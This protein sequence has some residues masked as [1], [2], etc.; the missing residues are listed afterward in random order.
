MTNSKNWY[1]EYFWN[2][3]G[4]SLELMYCDELTLDDEGEIDLLQIL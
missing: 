1:Y 3:D 4:I 2:R